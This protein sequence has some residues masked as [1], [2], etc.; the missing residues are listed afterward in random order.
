MENE[1]K[2]VDLGQSRKLVDEYRQIKEGVMSLLAT[3]VPETLLPAQK[4]ALRQAILAV[5]R[6]ACAF[7]PGDTA[8]LDRLRACYASLSGF[9]PP[10][11][12]LAAAELMR[13]SRVGDRSYLNSPDALRAMTRARQI[14]LEGA[15][16]GREF[17]RFVCK[18]QCAEFAELD[19]YLDSLSRK[20]G[21]A[22]GR[23]R[24]SPSA[25]FAAS[26]VARAVR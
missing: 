26:R 9:L 15:H 4:D 1:S 6:Q 13:A 20:Y 14:E 18:Q 17:D 11:Q 3:G 7:N 5:A 21:S 22:D 16:L 23:A 10:E 12:A 25:P 19:A 24:R 8:T 2:S